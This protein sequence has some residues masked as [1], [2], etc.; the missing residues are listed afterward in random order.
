MGRSPD[1][2]D[3][4]IGLLVLVGIPGSGKSTWAH[5]FLARHPR[6]QLVSTDQIRADLYGDE[7]IQGDWQQVWGQVVARWQQTLDQASDGSVAGV[8]YDAT[9]ARRRNRRQILA[10]ARAMGFHPITLVWFDMPL[11][12]CLRRNQLRSRQVPPDIIARMHHQL[13]GAPPTLT[14]GVD[15]IFY[16]TAEENSEMF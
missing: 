12:L 5:K 7:A 8:I 3:R 4:P 10:V 13:Q 6:Y 11:G 14:E 16:L 15:Q 1:M 2:G 9:N